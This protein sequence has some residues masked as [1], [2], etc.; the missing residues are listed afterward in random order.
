[1]SFDTW[2]LVQDA[3]P[4]DPVLFIE[5]LTSSGSPASWPQPPTLQMSFAIYNNS[6]LGD[7]ALLVRDDNVFFFYVL[8]DLED[9]QNS[10]IVSQ[11][12]AA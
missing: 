3:N 1:M 2:S 6:N 8:T 7:R 10:F 5:R 4:L 12:F 9:Q 11:T